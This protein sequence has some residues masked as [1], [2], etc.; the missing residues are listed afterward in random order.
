MPPPPECQPKDAASPDGAAEES[1]AA[2]AGLAASHRTVTT[3]AGA[4]T[5]AR[6]EQ[7]ALSLDPWRGREVLGRADRHELGTWGHALPQA[8]LS[9]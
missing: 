3:Y 1:A 2:R 4:G 6:Y 9:A 7:L 8:G 5:A